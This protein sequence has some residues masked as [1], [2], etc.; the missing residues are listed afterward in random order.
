MCDANQALLARIQELE[1]IIVLSAQTCGRYNCNCVGS[2]KIKK[3]VDAYIVRYPEFAK[4]IPVPQ[5]RGNR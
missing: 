2:N 3:Q 1:S 5:N 4:Q